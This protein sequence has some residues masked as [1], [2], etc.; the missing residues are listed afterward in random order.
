MK[1]KIA[2]LIKKNKFLVKENKKISKE[3]IET[4]KINEK[5]IDKYNLVKSELRSLKLERNT[6]EN[7]L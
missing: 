1:E 4:K 6:D 3:L 2:F 5:L 7:I